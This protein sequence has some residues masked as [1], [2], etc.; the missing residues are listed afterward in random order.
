MGEG[1]HLRRLSLQVDVADAPTALAL[2]AQVEE[3]VQ[4][5]LPPV[6]ERVMQQLAPGD[7]VVEIGRLAINL[8]RFRPDRLAEE[9]PPALERALV[10]A[11]SRQLLANPPPDQPPVRRLSP[12]Q[13]AL[14][15][16]D[17]WLTS[18][19]VPAWGR[20]SGF[21]GA[22]LLAGLVE[23]QPRAVA[24]LLL[25]RGR[26]RRVLERLVLQ[27]DL[28]GLG[29]VLSLLAPADA[30]IVRAWLV[31]LLLLHRDAPLI[32]RPDLAVERLLWL[33]TL[34]YLVQEAG[35]QFNRRSFLR[36]L[37]RGF[38]DA[39]G[40]DYAALLLLLGRGAARIARRRPLG[41]SLPALLRELLIAEGG[42]EAA[43]LIDTPGPALPARAGPVDEAV[44]LALLRQ[45]ARDPAL[46]SL[47]AARL[48]VRHFERLVRRME[49]AHAAPILDFLADLSR[50]QREEPVVDLPDD[51][52]DRLLRLLTLAD[53]SRDHGTGFN[54]RSFA[55]RLLRGLAEA[56]DIPWSRLLSLLRRALDRQARRGGL[57]PALPGLLGEV[58]AAE[59][60]AASPVPI[61][62]PGHAP[63]LP[64]APAWEAL[65]GLS[66]T[67]GWLALLVQRLPDAGFTRLVRQ[68]APDRA[69]PVLTCLDGLARLHRQEA[70]VPLTQ[71]RFVRLLR[72][73]TLAHLR[74]QPGSQFN[75]RSWLRRLLEDLAAA[76]K[77]A[78]GDLLAALAMAVRR[79]SQRPYQPE[80]LPGLIHEL[81]I[82]HGLEGE[83]TDTAAAPAAP[84]L[85]RLGRQDARA[86][87]QRI[88]RLAPSLSD[89]LLALLDLLGEA[90]ARL[91]WGSTAAVGRLRA[92]LLDWL[93]QTSAGQRSLAMAADYLRAN[94]LDL[95]VGRRD[96]LLALSRQLAA[97]AG[98]GMLANS[99]PP[100]PARATTRPP[101]PR[102]PMFQESVVESLYV[103]NAGLVLT[104]PFL[105]H[106]FSTLGLLLPA[107]GTA[108]IDPEQASRAVHLLQFL[109]DGR[110]DVPE[111]ELVLNKLL[112]GL[113]PE[114]PVAASITPTEAETSLCDQLLKAMLANWPVISSTSMEGLR[115]TFLQ[116]SGRLEMRPDGP[117]LTV[118][119]KTLD[120]LV[121]QVPWGFRMIFHPWMG[122]PVHVS[123]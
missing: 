106:F 100:T 65:A 73:L 82:D 81:A 97:A 37:L 41:S 91:G 105:P 36:R 70:L 9:V 61:P 13:V 47:F 24:A 79:T 46:L 25:Q 26:D 53:L 96:V 94:G 98:K 120:V 78:Y 29:R 34:E 38:A 88:A 122:Q 31:D 103:E 11:L 84:R 2:R 15:L 20:S 67:A 69:E 6:L 58:L 4:A 99:L 57:P 63:A 22:A 43:S 107:D 60:A 93:R 52:F 16:L 21:S 10:D 30:A 62:A 117:T 51:G 1:H 7:E 59:E 44:L 102:H 42:A 48:T 33:L 18:G 19:M 55:R 56:E 111:P 3:M 121:D 77:I 23:S 32:A 5:L 50:L 83:G 39:E 113:S 72:Q 80:T 45:A 109:V 118:Q 95:P 28:A 35:S 101:G 40:L 75:R 86:W 64:A 8:G 14:T 104:S 66:P 116:R 85:H 74:H 108:Q 71:D 17:H 68:L 110:C 54:R 90:L 89:D 12:D 92:A 76:E 87:R 112:C 27:L 123:W 49:P 115:E 119:R 114:T